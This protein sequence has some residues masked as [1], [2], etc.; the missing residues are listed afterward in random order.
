MNGSVRNTVRLVQFKQLCTVL[1]INFKKATPLTLNDSYLAG[2]FS[3]DGSLYIHSQL[4]SLQKK[5]REKGLLEANKIEKLTNCASP[6]IAIIITNKYSINLEEI[7]PAFNN[8]LFLNKIIGKIRKGPDP[9]KRP[10]LTGTY[11][12]EITEEQCVLIF[13]DYMNKNP[14]F[15]VKHHRLNLVTQFYELTKQKAHV[16]TSGASLNGQWVDFCNFYLR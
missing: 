16:L 2:Y 11:I 7:I 4:S 10:H 15:S 13:V 14:S 12:F 5:N 6:R 9:K 8:P 3:A 1:K